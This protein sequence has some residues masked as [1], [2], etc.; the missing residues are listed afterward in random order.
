MKFKFIAFV[1]SLTL[2]SCCSDKDFVFDQGYRNLLKNY[3]IGD[4]IYFKTL[5]GDEDTIMVSN[6][7]SLKVCS[8]IT[9]NH[10]FVSIE[11]KHLPINHWNGG[12]EITDNKSVY[13]DQELITVDKIPKDEKGNEVYYVGISFRDF[14]GE[15]KNLSQTQTDTL[16]ADIGVNKYWLVTNDLTIDR[17]DTTTIEKIVWTE[18]YGL[19]GYY[20]RNGDFYKIVRQ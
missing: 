6:I 17:G 14:I 3:Q 16:L 10:K 9:I 19:T 7:D 15:I 12:Q 8:F 4:T 5:N 13:L 2:T 11:I 20:K 1:F 18:K